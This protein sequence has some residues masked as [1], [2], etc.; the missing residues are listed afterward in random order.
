M[1]DATNHRIY[2]LLKNGSSRRYIFNKKKYDVPE[3][4]LELSNNVITFEPKEQKEYAN[5]PSSDTESEEQK[6]NV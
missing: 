1:S 3:P 6:M 4:I 5:E 2:L